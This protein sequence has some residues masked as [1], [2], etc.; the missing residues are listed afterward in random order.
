MVFIDVH[1]CQEIQ[2]IE[3][4]L[5]GETYLIMR[6]EYEKKIFLSDGPVGELIILKYG[7]TLKEL[8]FNLFVDIFSIE[9]IQTANLPQSLVQEIMSCKNTELSLGARFS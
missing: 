2:T 6:A 9:K 1:T 4:T 3:S 5:S 7:N 8:A